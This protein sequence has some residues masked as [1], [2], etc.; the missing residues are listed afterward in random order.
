MTSLPFWQRRIVRHGLG[1]LIVLVLMGALSWFG[2]PALGRDPARAF[3][4]LLMELALVA[5]PLYL[6]FALLTRLLERGHRAWYV[7]GTTAAL[8]LG[9]LLDALGD[10]GRSWLRHVPVE[11]YTGT[12]FLSAMVGTALIL[13]LGT[14]LRYARR[15]LLS[16]LQMR[17]LRARQLETELSLLKAQ[18]NQHFL[19][20]TLNNMYALSLTAPEQIPEALL[21]LAELMR[22]QLDSSRQAQ[23]TVGTEAEYLAN[24]IGLEKLRLRA[25]TQVEFS[26]DLPYPDRPLAPLLLLPLVE[27]C[28]KHA[29]GPNGPNHIR[30]SLVQT[31]VGLTLSTEN[32]IP[33]QFRA[34]PSG[35]GLPTL[36]ARLAQFYPGARHRLSIEATDTHFR[37]VL[38]LALAPAAEL[39]A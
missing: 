32:T 31:D 5:P 16:Q 37:A 38:H 18:V 8:V 9:A 1:W 36:R 29:V 21:Q 7:A 27:N 3:A 22:Y 23:V 17:R 10:V 12:D 2:A 30:I 15:G 14:G 24:Y 6:H 28:F 39:V 13:L 4:A 26:T 11:A 25:N 35:V 20:N 34:R 19:F 33:A